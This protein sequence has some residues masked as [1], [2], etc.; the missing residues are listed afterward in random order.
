MH[1]AQEQVRDFHRAN[2]GPAPDA[3]HINWNELRGVWRTLIREEYNELIEAID[4]GDT[5]AML[6]EGPDLLYVVYGLFTAAGIDL[7]P[8]FE[9]V[10]SANMRKAGGPTREDGKIL[11]PEGWVPPDIRRTFIR[12]YPDEL[13]IPEGIY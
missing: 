13:G 10:H 2:R 6:R 3:P 11:K 12:H 8:F 4:N 9:E 5:E 1:R 7:E